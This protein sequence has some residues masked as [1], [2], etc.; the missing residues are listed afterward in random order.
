VGAENDAYILACAGQAKKVVL[1]W[2]GDGLLGGRHDRVMRYLPKDKL[3]CWG[4]NKDGTPKMPAYASFPGHW[5]EEPSL[6]YTGKH[7][8][9]S[10]GWDDMYETKNM[11]R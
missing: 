7:T 10:R 4:I 9:F 11:L 6:K 5:G 8:R 3:Y 1:A 2:G